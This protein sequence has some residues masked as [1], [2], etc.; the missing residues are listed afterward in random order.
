MKNVQIIARFAKIAVVVVTVRPD[1]IYQ[2][3]SAVSLVRKTVK[4]VI[5]LR[6][7]AFVTKDV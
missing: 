3:E 5:A 2:M 1:I 4:I 7:M 6:T